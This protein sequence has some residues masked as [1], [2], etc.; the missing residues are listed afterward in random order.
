MVIIYVYSWD[1]NQIQ[2]NFYIAQVS[3]LILEML[4]EFEKNER[5]WK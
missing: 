4:D 2:T 1:T 5:I 3:W